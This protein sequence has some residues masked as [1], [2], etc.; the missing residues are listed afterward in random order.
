VISGRT[1][2]GR[3]V[4]FSAID[5]VGIFEGDIVLGTLEQIEKRRL[6]AGKGVEMLGTVIKGDQYRWSG[7]QVPYEIDPSLPNAQR[8]T[9]A[10]AHWEANTKLRFPKHGNESDYVVFRPSDG[11]SSSVG[12]QGGMQYVNLGPDCTAG[13][14]IHE[15]GHTIGLWHEQ[16]RADRDDFITIVWDNIIDGLEHNFLQ[17]ISD[18]DDAGSYDYGSIMHYPAFAF[19]KDTSQPTIV[20]KNGANIGQRDGLTTG[21]IS[22]SNLMY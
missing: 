15:I 9:D 11:C 4:Q 10:I 2:A 7:G 12:K 8:V 13:N 14:A 3:G 20:T 1:F 16:S 5:G 6:A 21:D 18:G 22:A 17:H 19:A